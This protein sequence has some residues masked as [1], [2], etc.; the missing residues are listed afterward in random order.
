M[1]GTKQQFYRE[2][3][4]NFRLPPNESKLNITGERFVTDWG[5]QIELEHY[6]RYLFAAEYCKGKVVLDIASGEGYGS[7]LLSQVADY[8]CGVDIDS[9]SVQFAKEKYSQGRLTFQAGSCEQIPFS[10]HYFDVIVS[11]E[12]IEHIGKQQQVQFLKEIRRVLKPEGLLIM[13]SP[14]KEVYDFFSPNNPFHVHE[15]THDEFRGLILDHFRHCHLL[16]QN[17]LTGSFIQ[18]DL[19]GGERLHFYEQ[20]DLLQITRK[21]KLDRL[22]YLICLASDKALPASG[23]GM[24]LDTYFDAARG[25]H[26]S[27]PN[28]FA[29]TLQ[30]AAYEREQQHQKAVE[31]N[32]LLQQQNQSLQQQNQSLQQR[33]QSFQQQNQLLQEQNQSFQQQNQLQQQQNQSLQQQNQSLLQQQQSLQ[34]KNGVLLQQ[35]ELLKQENQ[36]LKKDNDKILHSASWRYTRPLRLLM[37]LLR[38]DK[39]YFIKI[40]EA[41]K[42]RIYRMRVNVRQRYPRLST[43]AVEPCYFVGR[44]VYRWLCCGHRVALPMPVTSAPLWTSA[45]G[46]PLVSIIVPNFNHA[47]YLRQR[48]DSILNQTFRNFEILLLDDASVDDSRQILDQYAHQFPGTVRTL[49]NRKNSGNVSLQWKKGIENARGSLIWIAESDDFCEPDFLEKL[50]GFFNDDAVRLAYARP[51]F[52]NADGHIMASASNGYV[53]RA[54]PEKWKKPYVRFAFEEVADTL[55]VINSI[56]NVSCCVFR[57]P[58]DTSIL[59]ISAQFRLCGDWAFYLLYLKGWKVAFTPQACSYFRLNDKGITG[60]MT[61]TPDYF[62]EHT[63]IAGLIAQHYYCD[64]TLLKRFKEQ[65]HYVNRHSFKGVQGEFIDALFS[66]DFSPRESRPL[67]IMI[68]SMGFFLGGGE[69]Q[70]IRMANAL[71]RRGLNV[72]F[73]SLDI[74][75]RDPSIRNQLSC[76]IPVYCPNTVPQSELNTFLRKNKIDIVNTHGPYTEFYFSRHLEHSDIPIAATTHGGYES[77]LRDLQFNDLGRSEFVRHMDTAKKRI[78]KWIYIADKN[79]KHFQNEYA[80]NPAGFTKI[81]NGFEF[82]KTKIHPILKEAMGMPA[83]TFVCVCCSRAIEEKGWRQAVEVVGRA[84]AAAQKEIHL[85]LLGT[86]PLYEEMKSDPPPP[87]VCVLGFRNNVLDYM[88]GADAML[89]PTYFE[90]E[91][92]PLSVIESL[93]LK[94]PVIA[95]NVGEIPTMLMTS[96]PTPAGIVVPLTSAREPDVYLLAEALTGLVKDPAFYRRLAR[97]TALALRQFDMEQCT[98]QY[99]QCFRQ[100]IDA[101]SGLECAK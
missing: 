96:T 40:A 77:F 4:M 85:L 53:S 61:G 1:P 23:S 20:Q 39:G 65:L 2:H 13:S 50:I 67:G 91:S 70:P 47:R 74:Q 55:G 22:E 54:N 17:L 31:Q 58:Q 46:D 93:F 100:V 44:K 78:N 49:Y 79:L 62:E 101:Q 34:Q 15:I 16:S 87:Y 51:E 92:V 57:K 9:Q 73:F 33:N 25:V 19:A 94:K 35:S 29:G 60:Q 97:N 7:F 27:H 3:G 63:R 11:F 12:T 72:I 45:N 81:S 83:D 37:A 21:D 71:R 10:D 28:G 48:L 68:S 75:P 82:D 99:L 89:F 90:G 86:G 95:T 38:R 69:I 52:V 36:Y 24:Y 56:P 66:R 59:D 88:A 76:D 8:V 18:N 98:N 14:E 84:R 5:G 32:C 26:V 6:H 64:G 30:R 80:V 41:Q 42:D 43:L